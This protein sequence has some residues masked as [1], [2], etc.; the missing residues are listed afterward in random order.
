MFLLSASLH[1]LLTLSSNT[2]I[3]QQSFLQVD[4]TPVVRACQRKTSTLVK[5]LSY[6]LLNALEF[7][8]RAL[9]KFCKLLLLLLDVIYKIRCSSSPIFIILSHVNL[10]S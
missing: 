2:K 10:I 6:L 9:Y 4:V 5:H 3:V 1:L 8:Y 7:Q